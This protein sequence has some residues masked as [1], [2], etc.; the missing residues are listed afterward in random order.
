MVSFICISIFRGL[1]TLRKA[2]RMD[3]LIIVLSKYQQSEFD[4]FPT[5]KSRNFDLHFVWSV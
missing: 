1:P 3:V 4:A 5:Y 2:A